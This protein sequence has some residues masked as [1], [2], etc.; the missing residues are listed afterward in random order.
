MLNLEFVQ[1]TAKILPAYLGFPSRE[2][3]PPHWRKERRR[4][5]YAIFCAAIY[6][7]LCVIWIYLN[8]FSGFL[9][10]RG[11]IGALFVPGANKTYLLEFGV[12]TMLLTSLFIW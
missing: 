10:F 2:A 9:N 5:K 1:K 8:R 11:L 3:K 7:V 4:A 12:P 6:W